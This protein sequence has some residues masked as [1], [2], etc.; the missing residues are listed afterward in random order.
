MRVNHWKAITIAFVSLLLVGFGY[1]LNLWLAPMSTKA[2]ETPVNTGRFQLIKL[3]TNEDMLLDTATG[4]VFD[5]YNGGSYL[6]QI[7]VK[8]CADADCATRKSAIDAR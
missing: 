2:Q 8:I 4:R 3:K 1:E 5:F 6:Q 7:P